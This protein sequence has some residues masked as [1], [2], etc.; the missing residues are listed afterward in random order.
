MN[1]LLLACCFVFSF[2]MSYSQSNW[3]WVNPKPSGFNNNKVH[4]ISPDTG[5]IMNNNGDL[6]KT[7]NAGQS[8]SRVYSV[9]VAASMSIQGRTILIVPIYGA[10]RISQDAGNTWTGKSRDNQSDFVELCQVISAD[11]FILV[12]KNSGKVMRSFNGGNS[13]QTYTTG[14]TVSSFHFVNSMVGYIGCYSTN[15]LKTVNGGAT[16]QVILTQNSAPSNTKAIYFLNENKGFAFRE[17]STL[18]KTIDAGV[19]WTSVNFQDNISSIFFVNNLVGYMSGESAKVYRTADGGNTWQPVH[20]ISSYFDATTLFSTF[21]SDENN[22]YAVGMRGLI[23]KTNNGGTSWQ[24]YGAYYFRFSDFSFA[25]DSVAYAS[26]G[27]T[28]LKTTD[29][30]NSWQP[31]TNSLIFQPTPYWMMHFFSKDTGVVTAGEYQGWIFKTNDGGLTWKFVHAVNAGSNYVTSFDFVD[32]K[33]GYHV[34][35]GSY[36][37]H[38]RT[39]DGGETWKVVNQYSNVRKVEFIDAATGYGWTD[40]NLFKTI[41]SGKTWTTL[42]VEQYDIKSIHFTDLKNGFMVGDFGLSKK[43]TD[44]GKTWTPMQISAQVGFTDHIAIKFYDGKT[45]FLSTEGGLMFKTS[46]SGKTWASYGN[47]PQDYHIIKFLNATAYV[48]GEWG[49]II[50][51]ELAN[52][53]VGMVA[54]NSLTDSSV[55]VNALITSFYTNADSIGFEYGIAPALEK[56]IAAT[57]SGI[58]N[59]ELNATARINNLQPNTTYRLRAKAYVN[60][61]YIVSPAYS[62]F[63]TPVKYVVAAGTPGSCQSCSPLVINNTNNNQWVS[64][65]DA[66]GNAVA[67]INANGNE[68]GNVVTSLYVEDGSVRDT[69]GF[70]FLDR[71]ISI[72]VQ[73]QPTTPVSIKLYIL[74]SEYD[75]LA[76]IPAAG[77]GNV[78]ML[79]IQKNNTT[80]SGDL[81]GGFTELVTTAQTW[82][83]DYMLSAQVNSFSSFY[84]S[85]ANVSLP[86][87]L[88]NFHASRNNKQSVLGWQTLAESNGSHFEILRSRDGNNFNTIGKVMAAGQSNSLRSYSFID[89][90][91]LDGSNYYK[92]KIVDLDQRFDYSKV[93]RIDMQSA[94]S[95]SLLQNPV[96]DFVV[97]NNSAQFKE[98]QVIDTH[99]KLIK[100]FVP[101]FSNTYSVQNVVPGMYYLRCVGEKETVMIKFVKQ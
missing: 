101:S 34:V 50:K 69:S 52:A 9:S 82:G 84:F 27:N 61:S 58:S 94:T 87:R 76:Q 21:F 81:A 10:V 39:V 45:G 66:Q 80:C 51:S 96:N 36:A 83:N 54:Y 95:V 70:Y 62:V 12:S 67:D 11:T 16:W 59:Q 20:P 73:H 89:N 33:V 78:N 85:R 88:V 90:S 71:N 38:S 29:G 22:G 93:V 65:K 86:I 13:W 100:K 35:S 79:K 56:W 97:L 99:G 24:Q 26:A 2:S 92:L 7:S 6:L 41:D 19:T 98:I 47:T 28:L 68:L 30:G 37:I 48:G 77:I 53:S 17:H 72:L 32:N 74:K 31:L 75:K 14:R 15:I 40:K 64:V 1:K 91:A 63:T 55:N 4:F 49:G 8:W 42:G 25:T 5:F 3:T 18:L 23:Y 46:D 43:T 60:G 44:S 57:P